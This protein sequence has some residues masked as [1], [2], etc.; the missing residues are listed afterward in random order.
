MRTKRDRR[1]FLRG[2]RGMAFFRRTSIDEAG[3]A[4]C[5]REEG[6]LVPAGRFELGATLSG[7]VQTW[8]LPQ[9]LSAVQVRLGVNLQTFD[10]HFRQTGTTPCWCTMRSMRSDRLRTCSHCS[11][12]H[13]CRCCE[14]ASSSPWPTRPY[15]L[16]RTVEQVL[17]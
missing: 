12:S 9:S 8:P 15:A 14:C 4:S 1:M 3:M 17:L 2:Q 11:P 6:A 5:Y 7:H 10:S 13:R 16:Q